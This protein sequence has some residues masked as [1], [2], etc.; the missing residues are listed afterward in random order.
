MDVHLI[1]GTYEL[2]RHYYAVPPRKDA[3][4]QE[5]GAML[6]VM[7]SVLGMLRGGATHIG[8]ATDHIIE[9]FRNT[10][11]PGYKTGEGIDPALWRQFHPME[12]ALRA[13]GVVVWA[14]VDQEADDA[15]AAAATRAAADKNVNRI[16]ICTPDKDLAQCVKGKRVVQLDRRSNTVRDEDGV[17]EKFGVDPESIPDYLALVGDSADGFPGISGFGPKTAATLL[18]RYRHLEQ[19]PPAAAQWEVG[20]RNAATL[21]ATLRK[22]WNDA[23]LFRDLAT[24]RTDANV[25]ETVDDLK[26]RAPAVD[27]AVL[28]ETLGAPDTARTATELAKTRERVG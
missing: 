23:L 13:M 11:Y 3:D 5:V 26:W 17:R 25:F 28:C 20:L 8:V 16:F 9:S 21:S 18:A 2:F 24:L 10:M 4:G 6:G 27:F 14:M 22:S 19:I 12:D 15:L 1:D 7:N